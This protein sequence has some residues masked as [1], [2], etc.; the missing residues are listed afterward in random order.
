[1]NIIAYAGLNNC[2]NSQFDQYFRK[3]HDGLVY[4]IACDKCGEWFHGDCIGLSKTMVKIS[5]FHLIKLIF[6]L[7][8]YSN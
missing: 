3:G 1:M 2:F 4:M 7:I 5:F 8:I 6:F